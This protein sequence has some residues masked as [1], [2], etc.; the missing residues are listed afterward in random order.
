MTGFQCVGVS[1]GSFSTTLEIFRTYEA[2]ID[3]RMR[4]R[5]AKISK[6]PGDPNFKQNCETIIGRP[7]N[8]G[9]QF[10]GV[11]SGTTIRNNGFRVGFSGFPVVIQWFFQ[12]EWNIRPSEM[13]H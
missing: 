8:S 7:L 6:L 4:Q 11:F 9:F 3:V 1:V 10:Q 2:N 12:W 5:Y 13:S